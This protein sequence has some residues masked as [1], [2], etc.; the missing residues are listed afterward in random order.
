MI[1]V[2][3]LSEFLNKPVYKSDV[4][5]LP[6]GNRILVAETDKGIVIV[7]TKE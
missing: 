3:T 4:I 6:N 5:I 2:I 7:D 1:E